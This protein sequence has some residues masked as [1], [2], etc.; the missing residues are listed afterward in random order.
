MR[1]IIPKII[2]LSLFASFLLNLPASPAVLR[3]DET[4]EEMTKVRQLKLDNTETTDADL[5]RIAE[6]YP[7]LVELTL[8]GT[9]ISDAGVVHL[10]KLTK[11]RNLRISKSAI[12]DSVAKTLAKIPSLEIIDVSQT[13]F[14]DKGLAELKTL[15]KLKKLNLYTTKITDNGL[16][17]LKDFK[18]AKTLVWLNI[19]KCVL[20]DAAVVK[21]APLEKLEWLHLGRTALS[22]AGLETL[23][24][25]Q[26]LKEVSITN[27]NV[28][29]NGVAKLKA[30]LPNC[31]INENTESQHTEL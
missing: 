20:T 24:N 29:K 4:A 14:G 13:S 2:L 7:N 9:K 16:G 11:L 3:A 17:V 28:T 10:A 1:Y 23:A 30:A 19:D 31:K 26:T 21:L 18:S 6:K 8:S 27:T 25:Y 22:D 15:P 12:T 5:Q